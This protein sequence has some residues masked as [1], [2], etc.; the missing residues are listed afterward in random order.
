VAVR[1]ERLAGLTRHFPADAEIAIAADDRTA[2]VTSGRSRFLLPVFPIADLPEPHI[3]GEETGRVE[4]DAK[5]ARDLFARSAF[6]AADEASRPYLRGIFLHNTSDN[7]VAIAADGFRF[8]RVTTPATTT[9]SQDRSL[10]IPSEMV[11]TVNRLLG[12]ASGNV[13]LR[14]SERLFSV[15]GRGF[16]VISTKVDATY[17]DYE[18]W[19]PSEGPNVVTTSRATLSESLARFVAVADPQTRTHVVNLRWDTD[20]LHL[21]A[22]GSADCLAAD[23]EGEGETAAQVRYLVEL[24]GALRGDSVR[25]SVA[26]PGSMILV[27]DPEDE[28]FFAGQMPIRPRSS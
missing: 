27:T 16:V 17:P 9:L 24:I 1:L 3:L 6:A 12:N 7:L 15:E 26:E 18:R 23:V 19:I 22:D 5:V 28:N 2:T 10:I 8:C 4:L 25:I 14:R 13:T 11:K 20:G 21:R